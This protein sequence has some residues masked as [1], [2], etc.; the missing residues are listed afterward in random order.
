M[1]TLNLYKCLYTTFSVIGG[2]ILHTVIEAKLAKQ[3]V[4]MVNKVKKVL[5][6]TREQILLFHQII[7]KCSKQ[8]KDDK[9]DLYQP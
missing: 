8:E 5:D 9:A 3:L 4:H 2:G 7:L 1:M 6:A